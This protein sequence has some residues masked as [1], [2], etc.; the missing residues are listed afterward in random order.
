MAGTLLSPG[1]S[2]SSGDLAAGL[3]LLC[4][5]ALVCQMLHNCHVDQVLI[6]FDAE[7]RVI[8]VDCADLLSLHI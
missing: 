4:A 1:L 2:A 3:G 6:H 5:L 8:E 7:N